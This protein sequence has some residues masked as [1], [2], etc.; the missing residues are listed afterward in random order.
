MGMIVVNI[1]DETMLVSV[2][3][4]WLFDVILGSVVLLVEEGAE[5]FG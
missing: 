1:A 4:V 3:R 2:V 5:V